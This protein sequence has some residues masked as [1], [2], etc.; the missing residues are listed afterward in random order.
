MATIEHIISRPA[1]IQENAQNRLR[2]HRFYLASGIAFAVLVFVGF[3]KAYYLKPFF[4]SKP[5][6]S[7]LVYFHAGV[8]TAWVLLFA[9]QTWLVSAKKV[10]VHM[11]LGW[12]GVGLAL[13]V[14]VTGYYVSIGAE[15]HQTAADR[16]GIP[17]LAFMIIPITDL[18]MFVILFGAAIAWRKRPADHKRLML[19]TAANFLPPAA[20]RFPVESMQAL[21]PIFFFGV[22]TVLVIAALTYDVWR[23][24]RLNTAFL[25]GSILLIASF[26]LRLLIAGTDG[27]MRLA[28]WLTA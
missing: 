11:K 6:Y 9:T 26:P 8:M 7:T 12:I 20:A 19:L 14:L 3:S 21:G 4:D 1:V 13:L 10:R 25:V 16:G 17:P 5:F 27:W 2:E 23:S 28:E 22:P 15:A 18:V 24:R